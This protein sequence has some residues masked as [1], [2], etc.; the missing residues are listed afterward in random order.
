MSNLRENIDRNALKEEQT[1]LEWKPLIVKK[2][3][4]LESS[5]K[6]YMF[7]TMYSYIVYAFCVTSILLT[8]G[9]SASDFSFLRGTHIY[10]PRY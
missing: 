10:R 4:C 2:T 6:D 3:Y 7:T 5:K 9:V 1:A 8:S